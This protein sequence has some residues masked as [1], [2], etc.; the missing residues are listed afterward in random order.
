[1]VVVVIEGEGGRLG[2]FRGSGWGVEREE[3]RGELSGGKR[4]DDKLVEM[5]KCE[6]NCDKRDG[7]EEWKFR[8]YKKGK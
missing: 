6:E 2:G 7:G 8:K 3:M 1:M 4:T 5:M